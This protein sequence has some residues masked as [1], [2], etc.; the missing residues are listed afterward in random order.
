MDRE[1]RK[2]AM[3]RQADEMKARAHTQAQIDSRCR[4]VYVRRDNKGMAMA[5]G[6]NVGV[7]DELYAA[8]DAVAKA[9]GKTADELFEEA[10]R[11]LL[12]HKGLDDLA[13][14]G[15]GH[16]ERGGRPPSDAVSAVREVRRG[17]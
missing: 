13:R 3:L 7:S 9:E 14:R 1:S 2:A 16:A 10:G 6:K 8:V 12:E 17:R 4:P 5:D 11:K 15:A